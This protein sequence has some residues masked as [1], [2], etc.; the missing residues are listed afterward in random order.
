VGITESTFIRRLDQTEYA[1][2]PS[3]CTI[4]EGN[5]NQSIGANLLQILQANPPQ[6]I[7]PI[8][9]KAKPKKGGM[10]NF[11]FRCNLEEIDKIIEEDII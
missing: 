2:P 4:E 1:N 8:I 5:L 10:K 9:T 6:P 11:N 3:Q 7:I